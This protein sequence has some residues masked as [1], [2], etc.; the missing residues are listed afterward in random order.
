MPTVKNFRRDLA[1]KI[2]ELTQYRMLQPLV[3]KVYDTGKLN[4]RF[5][6]LNDAI[7]M[8][9][10][11]I[12]DMASKD[13]TFLPAFLKGVINPVFTHTIAHEKNSNHLYTQGWNSN[14]TPLIFQDPRVVYDFPT[15]GDI[16]TEDYEFYVFRNGLLMWREDYIV[17]NTAF[18]IKAFI[19]P[20]ALQDGDEVTL[21]VH[22]IFNRKYQMWKKSFTEWQAG[23]STTVDQDVVFPNFY[24]AKYMRLAVRRYGEPL[25][26]FL[27]YWDYEVF[28]DPVE[29]EIQ[30]KVPNCVIFNQFDTL[31][32]TDITNFWDKTIDDHADSEGNL[33]EVP[34]VFTDP[35]TGEVLPVASRSVRDFSVWLY[36]DNGLGHFMIPGEHFRIRAADF[37]NVT[38]PR[39]FVVFDR[40]IGPGQKFRLYLMKNSP[41]TPERTTFFTKELLDSK[42]IEVLDESKTRF[43]VITGA[44]ECYIDSKLVTPDHL[45]AIH[46]DILQVDGIQARG[47]FFYRVNAPI[48][49][50]MEALITTLLGTDS[51]F[52]RMVNL[53]GGVN[54]LAQR[55]RDSR[56]EYGISQG[57]GLI[58][59]G[60]T[61]D[62]QGTLVMTAFERMLTQTSCRD[63]LA[64]DGNSDLPEEFE[65]VLSHD[66][67]DIDSNVERL[68]E[69]D[70]DSNST[71]QT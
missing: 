69:S 41:Y 7:R 22:R 18:G 5:I 40:K 35:A 57:P 56:L 67:F 63:Y 68:D 36:L 51:E 16:T 48:D 13:P 58:G 17:E 61:P 62:E 38:E 34:L 64:L 70:F 9:F 26:Q 59:T 46:D 33:P 32:M 10:E 2:Y 12:A 6:K 37:G 27:P 23:L 31:V 30:I 52:D 1:G 11:A 8:C 55:T 29:H 44:G 28:H 25:Y 3:D 54:S 42:G 19:K 15:V 24:S 50:D 71:Y 60:L 66:D 20:E 53:L 39:E 43:P 4:D 49:P 65:M 21:S 47:S 14:G 45:R